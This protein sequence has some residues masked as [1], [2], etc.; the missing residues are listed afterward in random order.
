MIAIAAIG[1][2]SRDVVAGSAPRPGGGVFYGARALA[3]MGAD[4]CIAAACAADDRP[5]LFQPL[6]T[7]GLP[8]TWRESTTTTAY[9]FHYEGE[10]RIMR[11]EAVGDPWTPTQAVRAAGGAEWINVCALARSDFSPATLAALAGDGRRLLV[12]A[13][14]LV[15]TP[16][17]GPLHTDGAIGDTLRHVEILNLND[18]EAATLVG[19]A[20][21][22]RLQTLGV[23]EVLLT[24]GSRGSFVITP[25]LI[26]HVPA[27][28][29]R[30]A[31]DSTGAGDT[32]AATYLAQ[33]VAGAEPV[34]AARVASATVAAFLA[35]F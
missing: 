12:D 1:H 28:E 23:P 19:S 6:E 35:D 31:V 4:A 27:V 8:V 25:A 30:R 34:E 5:L 16:R 2:I 22:E 24:L 21:P 26:E 9:S 10:R 18:E 13:Q 20:D 17:I 14:G 7:L 11:V 33:R 3:R 29:V 32:Y 15:R